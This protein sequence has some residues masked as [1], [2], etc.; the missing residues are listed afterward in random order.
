M[1]RSTSVTTILGLLISLISGCYADDALR[2]VAG[3]T[4]VLLTDA[5]FP[6]GFVSRVE[7]YVVE[8][9]A[10]MEPDTMSP[11]QEWITIDRPGRRFDLLALQQGRTALLGEAELPVGQY[12]AVRM[13]INCAESSVTLADGTE[14]RVRWPVSGDLA[15]YAFVEGPVAVLGDGAE[16]VIDLDVGR[17]FAYGLL[18]PLHDFI[19]MPVIRAVNGAATGT[20]SGRVFG[21]AN[22]DEIPEALEDAAITVF[23]GNH[24]E[25]SYTWRIAATGH[26]D[27]D[28]RYKVAYLPAGSYIVQVDAPAT[29]NL[30]NVTTTNVII[31]AGEETTHSVTLPVF[32]AAT[33]SIEGEPV[34]TVGDTIT[35]H[36]VV[37]DAFGV[38]IAAPSVRWQSSHPEI[39]TVRDIGEY[40]T[41]GGIS[42]GS[43]LVVATS[44]GISDSITVTVT[45]LGTT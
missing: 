25:P 41:I 14:A 3:L 31:A 15:M 22:G 33:L 35:L 40:T 36:A 6:F 28:G 27:P 30:G 12:R 5:P 8:I 13:T 42:A 37:R 9:A 34:V 24:T 20:L 26:T 39:A 21:D 43:A 11:Q 29:A 1:K 44:L 18:D 4:R 23:S 17:S 10:S 2:P 45:P 32:G 7:V 38:R 16:I 19:F